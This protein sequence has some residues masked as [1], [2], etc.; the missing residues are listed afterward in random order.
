MSD[1]Y[2]NAV[3]SY[4]SGFTKRYEIYKKFKKYVQQKDERSMDEICDSGPS[5]FAL[6]AQQEF[7]REY[8]SENPTWKKLLL[9]H[10]LGSGKTCTAITMA[11]EYLK[12]YPN[13]MYVY[14]CLLDSRPT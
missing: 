4:G 13:N 12:T 1:N 5:G 7:L 2:D 8:M 9:Y 14:F 11:E 3:I 6:Q 10:S